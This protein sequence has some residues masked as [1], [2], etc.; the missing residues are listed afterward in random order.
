MDFVDLTQWRYGGP[1]GYANIMGTSNQHIIRENMGR[2]SC[3]YNS[4]GPIDVCFFG[5]YGI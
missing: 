2:C 4:E 3:G 5:Y 1:E